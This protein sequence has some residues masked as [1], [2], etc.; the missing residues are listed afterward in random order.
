MKVLQMVRYKRRGRRYKSST[1]TIMMKFQSFMD[2]STS[3]SSMQILTISAG[4]REVLRR[5]GPQFA[6]YKYYKLGNIAVKL[7]PASTLPV[8][9]T[10]L[11][12]ESGE[13]GVDP[14]D[15]LTP[16]MMRITNGEDIFEDLSGLSDDAQHGI[17]N[18]M[19]LDP[20]WFKWMLQS[21]VKRHATP[22]YWQIGQLHQ[23]KFPGAVTN[24][25][26]L[27]SD[28]HKVVNTVQE[29]VSVTNGASAMTDLTYPG[30]SPYALF[31]TGHMGRLG[32][33]PTDGLVHTV[34]GSGSASDTPLLASPPEV[35]V[36]KIILPK[37]YK[38]RYYYRMFITETVYF[39]EPIV[40]FGVVDA[41]AYGYLP[42]D[43]FHMQG[44]PAP[45]LPTE[46]N[47]YPVPDSSTGGNYG[48][49]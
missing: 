38:T 31:Q 12:L 4:G 1:R 21:G 8:D 22:R 20:R 40:N 16:G 32:W 15:Q 41:N 44:V 17:Y 49:S 45:V 14:R 39:K 23:D 30:S 10:G 34:Y 18:N 26:L 42:L 48:N 43:V 3:A 37:A 28:T 11:S 5:L 47:Q 7:V 36:M 19:I 46:P 33:M 13:P 2:I 24:M 29:H 9:P 35:E 27:T 6:A 25:P